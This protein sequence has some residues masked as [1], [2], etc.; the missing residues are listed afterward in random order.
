MTANLADFTDWRLETDI[1]GILWAT[2]DRPGQSQN[3]MSRRGTEELAGIIGHAEEQ[4]KVKAIK[5][6]VFISGKESSFIAG[7]DIKEFDHFETE[8]AVRADVSKVT[9]LLDRLEQLPIPVVAAI[10]G[11]CLGGGLELAMA[12]HYRIATRDDVTRLGLPEINLG[13]F[14]GFNGTA[15]AIRLVGPVAG[16]DMMLRG[17]MLRA[18]VARGMGLVDELVPARANLHWAARKAVLQNKKSVSGSVT[19]RIMRQW[20]ARGYLAS[21]M[22]K[23]VA[24]KAREEHLP[25]PYRLIDLFEQFGGDEA[26]MKAAETRAFAPLMISAQSRNLRRVFVLSEKM[27]AQAPKGEF[28]PK[29]AHV[30]GAGTMGADIAGVMVLAGME[31]S[32]QDLSAEQL[33]KAQSQ[34]KALFRKRLKSKTENDAAMARLIL[35]PTGEHVPRADVIIEAIVEKLEAKQGLFRALEP[36]MKPGAVMASNTSSIMIEKMAEG[37]ADPGR[38]IGLHFFNPVPALPLVEVVKGAGSRDEEVRKGCAIVTAIGKYPLVVK[39]APG[40]LVNRVLLPYMMAAMQRL[41][42]GTAREMIDEAAKTFGMP[43]GPIELADQVGLDICKHVA[44]IIGGTG[45]TP[46]GSKLNQLVSAGKLGKKSGEGFYVWKDG[47]VQ[48]TPP[49]TPFDSKA[50]HELGA[51]LV[52]PLIN[53]CETCLREG[54]VDSADMVD[55]GVIFGTG[56]APFRGG[57]L[58]YRQSL[59]VIASSQG[60]TNDNH[61]PEPTIEASVSHTAT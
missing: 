11:Y 28:K 8:E 41:E 47:K 39:S 29:R 38:L 48:S 54:V 52:E 15:R 25:A 6:L 50:L 10:H 20:P 60:A 22:R 16:M 56:F 36:R 14:P 21:D 35:D 12:C 30:I 19:H 26:R 1:E 33:Q 27:K 43:V 23:K 44:D 13:I 31:V 34:C 45:A 3:T 4:A 40:F 53:E 42:S 59:Q 24:L 57:P 2:L 37:L 17:S 58:H 49:A 9:A 51:A 46:E 7:A 55:A 18:N 32:L 61:T 5:G